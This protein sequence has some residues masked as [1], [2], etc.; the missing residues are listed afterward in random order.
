MLKRIVAVASF[1]LMLMGCGS[2]G[3]LGR[4]DTVPD[5]DRT[6]V[7]DAASSSTMEVQIGRHAAQV[8]SSDEIRQFGQRMVEDHTK[9]REELRAAAEQDGVDVPEQM[10]PAHRT[11]VARLT[12]VAGTAFDREYL[13]AAVN[14]YKESVASFEQQAAQG[15]EPALKQFAIRTLPTLRE[16]LQMAQQLQEQLRQQLQETPK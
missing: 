10:T 5:V 12:K 11:E 8:A 16:H 9:A 7:T 4:K 13:R 6:F 14:H 15:N 2:G 3:M 1:G